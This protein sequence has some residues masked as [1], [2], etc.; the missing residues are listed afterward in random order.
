MKYLPV[1][2]VWANISGLYFIFMSYHIIPMLQ[3]P[4]YHWVG[5]KQVIIF[6]VLTAFLMICNVMC[7]LVHPGSIPEKEEDPSWEYVPPDQQTGPTA[8]CSVQLQESKRTGDRRHCKWC[9]K[10]KP[11]RCHHCRVCRMCI[12]KMDHHCPWIYN[13]VGYKN[14][15]YFFLLL[16]YAMLD[17]HFIFWNMLDSVKASTDPRTPFLTMFMLLLGESLAAS[18]GTAVTA[19]LVFHIWLILKAMTTIEFCEKSTKKYGYNCSAYDRGPWRNFTAVLGENVWLWFLPLSMPIG[20]GLSFVDEAAPLAKHTAEVFV[21][22]D[23][24]RSG[25]SRTHDQPQAEFGK[26]RL[27]GNLVGQ[28][29]CPSSSSSTPPISPRF[30]PAPDRLESQ[31]RAA[32]FESSAPPSRSHTPPT[33]PPPPP[34]ALPAPASLRPPSGSMKSRP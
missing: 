11:D 13:C 24:G 31:P 29:P 3:H 10:Y 30:P 18:L 26:R 12:L 27:G 20:N 33:P 5:Q 4:H 1:I 16:V 15:K 6:N 32:T 17:C 2:F 25:T 19:F 8:P 34:P 14:H 9:Q 21:A 7:I 22:S 28:Q 23:G